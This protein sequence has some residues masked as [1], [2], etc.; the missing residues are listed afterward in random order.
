MNWAQQ[1][2]VSS[3]RVFAK[4]QLLFSYIGIINFAFTR[5]FVHSVRLLFS[6]LSLFSVVEPILSIRDNLLSRSRYGSV[7]M[8]L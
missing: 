6:F 3:G 2:E 5:A 8:V 4:S 7:H 1:T